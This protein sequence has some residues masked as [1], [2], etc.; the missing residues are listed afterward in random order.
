MIDYDRK[1]SRNTAGQFEPVKPVKIRKGFNKKDEVD[2][3]EVDNKENVGGLKA[4]MLIPV[5]FSF[6]G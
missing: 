3:Q 2:N 6:S 5:I 4:E 1:F